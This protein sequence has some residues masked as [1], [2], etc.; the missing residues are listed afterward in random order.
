[1]W[2]YEDDGELRGF[3]DIAVT[4][5]NIT[6]KT[7]ALLD[8]KLRRRATAPTEGI[9][10]LL[11][12]FGNRRHGGTPVGAILYYSPGRFTQYKLSSDRG[13]ELRAIGLDPAAGDEQFSGAADLALR[14][15]GL[16]GQAV[17]LLRTPGV[18]TDE[19]RIEHAAGVRQAIAVESMQRA[20]D[21]LP[22]ATLAPTRKQTAANLHIIWD[23]LRPYGVT[24]CVTVRCRPGPR[25]RIL[26]GYRVRV[27]A[28]GLSDR[29]GRPRCSLSV[30]VL[31]WTCTRGRSWRR[32]SMV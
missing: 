28:L 19:D 12:Y 2:R 15:A 23:A 9:Y 6:G 18:V 27:L 7:L 1:M 21:A 29:R 16:S 11:G 17:E 20:A 3:P 26:V 31:G 10:K 8:P 14:I 13:G 30:R 22:P 4:A 24:G 25:S 5:E 32:R